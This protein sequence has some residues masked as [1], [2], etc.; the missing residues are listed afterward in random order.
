MRIRPQQNEHEKYLELLTKD[1]KTGVYAITCKNNGKMYIGESLDIDRRWE[2][3]RRHLTLGTHHSKRLQ[4][5]WDIY[6]PE[7]FE[8]EIMELYDEEFARKAI[9]VKPIMLQRERAFQKK[10]DTLRSGYNGIDTVQSILDKHDD[11][12]APVGYSLMKYYV[13]NHIGEYFPPKSSGVNIKYTV[14]QRNGAILV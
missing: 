8:F 12:G 5:D 7:Y 1:V 11:H 6:G 3:H 2:V 9:K 10:F 13:D 4:M 14:R